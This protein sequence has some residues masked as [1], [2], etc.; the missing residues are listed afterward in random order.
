MKEV[1]KKT[2]KILITLGLLI[3]AV[4]GMTIAYYNSHKVF[5]NEFHVKAPGVSIYEK[6]NPTDWWVPGEEK[7]KKAWFANTGELDMLLRFKVDVKWAE[8]QETTDTDEKGNPVAARDVITLYWQDSTHTQDNE[9][10]V[11]EKVPPVILKEA[12]PEEPVVII[13]GFD[14]VGVYEDGTTYYYYKKILEAK[15]SPG[16]KTQNVL[17]SVKFSSELS[18]DGH[19][20]SDYSSTQIDLTITGETV[21]VDWRAVEEMGWM[22][23]GSGYKGDN[24]NIDFTSELE[25]PWGKYIEWKESQDS[26]VSDT[27]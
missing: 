16:Y 10:G 21:L 3:T 27:Q 1:S 5:E 17:E 19:K 25:I 13:P 11:T 2:I 7:S 15:G 9:S 26:G 24:G 18:N 23:I 22:E 8:G 14:F 12:T 20:N 6:F 4:I